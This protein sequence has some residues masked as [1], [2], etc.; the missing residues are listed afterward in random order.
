M[1]VGRGGVGPEHGQ[2]PE[3]F[4]MHT[5]GLRMCRRPLL[6]TPRGCS[7]RHRS[8]DPVLYFEHKLLYATKGEV[9]ED[10]DL[11][12]PMG[13]TIRREGDALTLVALSAM[14]P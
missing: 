9:S 8:D 10:P 1:P 4:F 5:P 13:S 6:L 14:L 2:C 12:V 7:E 11:L 3:A